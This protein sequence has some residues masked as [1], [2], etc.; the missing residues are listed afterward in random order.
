LTD[1]TAVIVPKSDQWNADDFIAGPMTFT[2]TDVKVVG[3]TEQP[4]S[5]S[6][7]G[8][9]KFYRPCKSMSRVLVAAWGPDAKAYVGRSL[10]LYRDPTVKWGGMAVGGIRISHMTDIEREMTLMLTMTKQN[11][12]PHKVRL[13]EKAA[14][15][16]QSAQDDG[17]PPL[18]AATAIKLAEAAARKGTDHFR[19]WFNTDAGK[20]CRA[21]GALTPDEMK[22]LKG[23]CE[24][25][26]K[27][28]DE[29]PFG[30]PPLDPTPEQLAAA[31]AEA[32]AAADALA[33]QG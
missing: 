26:D 20:D 12:A 32:R 11:R 15:A 23:I 9:P 16:K 21:T 28:T 25:T 24:A 17:L 3:G 5:I 31:E 2:I 30:L 1:M 22:R 13:L 18:D 7:Q 29:D 6:V 8:S 27:A 33:A 19:A 4:V 14:P 10:T